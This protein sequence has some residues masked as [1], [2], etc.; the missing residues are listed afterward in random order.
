MV[1]ALVL[2]PLLGGCTESPPSVCGEDSTLSEVA[3][4]TTVTRP[5]S[6]D[7]W[8]EST[9]G[10]RDCMSEFA[11]GSGDLYSGFE[12]CLLVYGAEL[13]NGRYR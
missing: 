1:V 10:Y 11:A 9:T 12:E 5:P 8:D 2:A 4:G 7:P 3:C 13:V 6:N